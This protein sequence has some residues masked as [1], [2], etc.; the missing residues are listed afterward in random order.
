MSSLTQ[1][2]STETWHSLAAALL[3][4]GNTPGERADFSTVKAEWNAVDAQT[5]GPNVWECLW[6][7]AGLCV[8]KSQGCVCEEV[9]FGVSGCVFACV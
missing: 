1:S 9:L 2:L 7:C 6:P 3:N 5:V 4:V 8:F